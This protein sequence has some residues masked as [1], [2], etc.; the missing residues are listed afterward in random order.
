MA[1]DARQSLSDSARRQLDTIK[2]AFSRLS[3]RAKPLRHI[4]A[5]WASAG[6]RRQPLSFRYENADE[7]KDFVGS[8]SEASDALV[9]CG[10][11]DA[12]GDRTA[13]H[14]T[15]G[16]RKF[17]RIEGDFSSEPGFALRMPRPDPAEWRRF[18]QLA[19]STI[20]IAGAAIPAI[21]GVHCQPSDPVCDWVLAMHVLLDRPWFTWFARLHGKK[22]ET[23]LHPIGDFLIPA[24]ELR[25]AANRL[26]NQRYPGAS[27][28][29]IRSEMMASLRG[30]P[31][32]S[33]PDDELV[34][35]DRLSVVDDVVLDSAL[36][37][38]ALLAYVDGRV[39]KRGL[40]WFSAAHLAELHGVPYAAFRRRL[41]R[42]RDKSKAGEDY[43]E[44]D[45]PNTG[46][47]RYLYR[48]SEFVQ[49]IVRDLI[50][51]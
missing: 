13:E 32:D 18:R 47:P 49:E 42:G 31:D 11:G 24:I 38:D 45:D 21:P 28:A 6:R 50:A 36:A 17:T 33:I 2:A 16:H 37:V 10:C 43:V 20:E 29:D 8:S 22:V 34:E 35:V 48:E 44:Y 39:G 41:D 30:V 40:G 19:T 15:V 51:T 23:Y 25:N 5:A 7:F 3:D 46:Q 1:T 26:T 12:Y 27:N 14:W 4:V 9:C